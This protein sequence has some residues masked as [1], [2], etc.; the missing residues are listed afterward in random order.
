MITVNEGKGGWTIKVEIR[1]IVKTFDCSQY[2]VTDERRI[3]WF[4]FD[5]A[6]LDAIKYNREHGGKQ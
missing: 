5:R 3:N 2:I 6:M 1:K 4:D